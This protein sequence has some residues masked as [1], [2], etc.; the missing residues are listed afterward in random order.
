MPPSLNCCRTGYHLFYQT[1]A[2]WRQD[3]L[4]TCTEGLVDETIRCHYL[5]LT[6]IWGSAL[7]CLDFQCGRIGTQLFKCLEEIGSWEKSLWLVP[8]LNGADAMLISREEGL[9]WWPE[10][11]ESLSPGLVY[12]FICLAHLSAWLC[13]SLRW[14]HV[15]KWYLHAVTSLLGHWAHMSLYIELNTDM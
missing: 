13:L 6:C 3:H 5:T 8:C 1:R 9:G 4:L 14:K 15:P 7:N 11:Q 12:G 10:D 2:T